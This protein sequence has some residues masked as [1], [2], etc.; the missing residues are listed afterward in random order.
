M[1]TNYLHAL[2]HML[3]ITGRTD[4]RSY[5]YF[6]LMVMAL[7]CLA[8][9]VDSA[10]VLST[11][12]DGTPEI[13]IGTM[14]MTFGALH[15]LP[16]FSASVRRL[17]DI[18]KS[19]IWILLNCVPFVGSMILFSWYARPSALNSMHGEAPRERL[20]R[21]NWADRTQF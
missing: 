2:T 6:I 17:H 10:I 11:L 1:V 7:S 16:I 9:S 13:K 14:T 18:G 5:W 21:P 8:I 19:G 12:T 3:D 15:F 20:S 4:R